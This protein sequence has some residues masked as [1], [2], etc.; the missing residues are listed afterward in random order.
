MKILYLADI[1]L[2][3][4][5]AHGIQIVKTCEA[6]SRLGHT[7]KLLIA[8]E[9]SK[10]DSEIFSCYSI[11]NRFVIEK[12]Y[13]PGLLSLGRI[14]FVLRSYFFATMARRN[15]AHEIY[16]IVYTRDEITAV[17]FAKRKHK[18]FY[19]IHDVRSG[20]F[21]FQQKA[22]R[23]AAGVVCISEG[24]KKH[25]LEQGVPEKKVTVANDGVDLGMFDIGVDKKYA[26]EKLNLPLGKKLVLYS[27]HL[28]AWK[29]V[30]TLAKAAQ[31]LSDDCLVVFVGGN[32]W[33]VKKSE[34]KW[35][36]N[37]KVLILGH[38]P[39]ALIPYYLKAAD[40]VVLPNSASEKISKFYTSPLKLFEY[41]ASGTPIVASDLPSLREVLDENNCV[42]AA[43]DDENLL[44]KS[45]Q[46]ALDNS[47]K[48][49]ILSHQALS[50]VKKYSWDK[51]AETIVLFATRQLAGN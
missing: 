12:V 50:D 40:V 33:D 47:S 49:A 39:Q 37:N 14:G 28:Y 18:V 9:N 27:G 3:T 44:A 48:V 1:R 38:R 45:I 46:Y 25:C 11:K 24:L 43:A 29:G 5:K 41:M 36:G 6:L 22:L 15:V 17:Q 13:R 23:L 2:P 30:D 26:R 21:S 51:R 7:V 31:K 4:A 32:P 19:E 34:A 8:A 20:M 10:A 42:F 35:Q 16:D